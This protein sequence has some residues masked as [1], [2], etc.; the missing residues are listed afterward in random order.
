M[1][2]NSAE[3][4]LFCGYLAILPKSP[5]TTL[6]ELRAACEAIH[7]PDGRWL[8]DR[9]A[10]LVHSALPEPLVY[11]EAT[12]A[13][14]SASEAAAHAAFEA[15]CQHLESGGGVGSAELVHSLPCPMPL[16]PRDLP[17]AK[18]PPSCE[19]WA[20][21]VAL[22][23]RFGVIALQVKQTPYMCTCFAFLLIRI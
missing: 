22:F 4:S 23:K 12:V 21:E 7:V 13:V 2:P 18:L 11:L 20:A 19:E 9:S 3:S 16:L 14:A 1:A 15:I 8:Q 5:T 17:V 6:D 10:T